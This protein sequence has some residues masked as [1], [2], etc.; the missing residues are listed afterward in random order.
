MSTSPF[1]SLTV[2]LW[3]SDMQTNLVLL[4]LD[5]LVPRVDDVAAVWAILPRVPLATGL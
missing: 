4:V 5:V 1:G 3:V 2:Q